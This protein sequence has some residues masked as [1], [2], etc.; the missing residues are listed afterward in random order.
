MAT[1]VS[2]INFKGGVG[3]TTLAFH[4][5]AH[6]AQ[7]KKVLVIDVDHQSSL[8]LVMLGGKLWE[9]AA[10]ARKTCNTIF[11][12]FCNRKVSMPSSEIIFKN[13]LN[14]RSRNYDL[15]PNLDLVPGQFELDDTEIE[16][17]STTVGSATVS[18]WQKRTLVA[19][20]LDHVKADATYDYIIFD[21]PPA[22]KLVSQNALAASNYFVV[23]VIPD[24]MSSRGVTHFRN[25]VTEKIDKKLEFLH[26]GA[27]ISPQETPKTYVPST[28]LAAIVAFLAKSAGRASSGLTNIH[29]E[30]LSALRRRWGK[31][32]LDVVVKNMTG[33]AEAMDAGWPVWTAYETQNIKK[34]IPMMRDVCKEIGNRLVP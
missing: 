1:K 34:V 4:L 29:T 23:P 24:D 19:E 31:D 32:F 6:L 10:K 30:Q 16:L 15:Y 26:K 12:S 9:E 7:T 14:A 25:L 18:E 17:A 22:T 11:E 2:V 28:K 5:A 27:G 20:W 13:P 8:S 33:V 3:K 21:C